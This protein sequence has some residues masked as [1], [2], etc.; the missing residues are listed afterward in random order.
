M[1]RWGGALLVGALVLGGC[2]SVS[3]ATAMTT[4]AAQSNYRANAKTL[5]ATVVRSASALG[6]PSSTS[7]DLH[8]VCAVLYLEA[9]QLNAPLPTPDARATALVSGALIDIGRG[10]S[11][12]YDA[13]ASESARRRSIAFFSKGLGVLSE[14][15]ARIASIAAP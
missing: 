2:G 10:A 11:E 8:T 4:W 1:I 14:A 13:S 9:D 6:N 5:I 7:A 15:T 12:C 3:P